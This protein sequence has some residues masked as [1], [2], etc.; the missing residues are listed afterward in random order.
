MKQFLHSYVFSLFSDSAASFC[1]NCCLKNAG[2]LYRRQDISGIL[3][4]FP[5][6][7]IDSVENAARP[8]RTKLPAV[9]RQGNKMADERTSTVAPSSHIFL[10]LE[11]THACLF[12]LLPFFFDATSTDVDHRKSSIFLSFLFGNVL[13]YVNIIN[14]LTY[15]KEFNFKF[16]YT[17]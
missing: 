7:L 12:Y 15:I 9:K 13:I 11:L 4:G 16:T 17:V 10:V 1:L 8:A 2:V 3:W 5:V 6:K 14:N